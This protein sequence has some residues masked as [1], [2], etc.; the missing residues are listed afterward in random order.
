MKILIFSQRY[1]PQIGGIEIHAQ[2]VAHELKSRNHQVSVG[3]VNFRLINLSSRLKRF[4]GD[5]FSPNHPSHFDGCIPIISLS[6]NWFDR[7]RL[8]PL[9]LLAIGRFNNEYYYNFGYKFYTLVYLPKL[10]KLIKDADIVHLIGH[11]T[12]YFA[13]AICTVCQQQKKPFVCV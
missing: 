7:F 8:L 12:D 11:Y 13:R 4:G 1:Y 2:Q 9:L 3:A 10:H 6:P 5:L